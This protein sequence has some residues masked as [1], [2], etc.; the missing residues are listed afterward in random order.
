MIHALQDRL[1]YFFGNLSQG[2]LPKVFVWLCAEAAGAIGVDYAFKT[3]L[4]KTDSLAQEIIPCYTMIPLIGGAIGLDSLIHRVCQKP[5]VTA[6]VMAVASSLLLAFY[7]QQDLEAGAR[8]VVGVVAYNLSGIAASVI[9]GYY[10]LYMTGAAVSFPS[11][12]ENTVNAVLFGQAAY[13]CTGSK[14]AKLSIATFGYNSKLLFR[15]I[16]I[17][18]DK[19]YG[20][21]IPALTEVVRQK[22]GTTKSHSLASEIA[23]H[24][25]FFSPKHADFIVRAGLDPLIIRKL[26][27][28]QDQSGALLNLLTRSI[29]EYAS[30][31]NT[32]KVNSL[33]EQFHT[34]FLEH[35]DHETL[36]RVSQQLDTLLSEEIPHSG[37]LKS[38]TIRWAARGLIW[39][40]ENLDK[41]T[42][43]IVEE[44]QNLGVYLT[45]FRL[46]PPEHIRSLKALSK[47]HIK[48]YLNFIVSYMAQ[49]K[50][51]ELP[52]EDKE[53]LQLIAVMHQVVVYALL[54]PL[55]PQA[56][57]KTI[58]TTSNDL[59]QAL[60]QVIYR[61]QGFTPKARWITP[62]VIIPD[63]RRPEP[64]PVA[65]AAP[66]H[67]FLA[68][69]NEKF[70]A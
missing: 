38:M 30:L 18:K 41:I 6:G 23:P 48:N 32:P 45:G 37:N 65:A 4:D 55:L 10:G 51:I 44:L 22:F 66:P 8:Q 16:R 31:I 34:L 35:K 42:E 29:I 43:T 70:F 68:N 7:S 61:L 67:N 25:P 49:Q 54:K 60:T 12:R 62:P 58:N 64:P 2:L 9:G 63:Y 24:I 14:I 21:L 36:I 53:E 28:F 13:F 50:A 27:D 26:T 19:T 57:L 40:D 56:L 5:K 17:R 33:T 39:N 20:V 46:Y 59:I 11:Y 15:A 52:L 47:I 1:S 3:A 69:V